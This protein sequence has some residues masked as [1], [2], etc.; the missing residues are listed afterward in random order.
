MSL[1]FYYSPQ[2][3]ATPVHWALEELGVPYEKVHVDVR[4]GAQNTPEFLALN[5][6]AKVPVVVHDGVAIFESA[7]IQLYLGE[8]FGVDKGLYPP[9]SPARGEIMKWIVWTNVTLGD[10]LWTFG[11]NQGTWT[12]ADE[13]NEKARERARGEVQRLLGMLDKHME[14]REYLAQ[15]RFSIGDVH[16]VSWLDYVTM[17]GFSLAAFPNLK[18]WAARCTARPAHGRGS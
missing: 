7:A 3:S 2:S 17:M 16:L 11:R 4:A 8:T 14:G 18:A 12:P 13:Q 15:E 1:T 10:A 6:N 9:P 5:P